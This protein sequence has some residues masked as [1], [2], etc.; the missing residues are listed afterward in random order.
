[1]INGRLHPRFVREKVS[2]KQR[3]G[4][5]VRDAHTVVFVISD[6]PVSF[7]AFARLFRDRTKCDNALFLDGGY[8]PSLY[9]PELKHGDNLLPL[10][11]MIGEFEKPR[12]ADSN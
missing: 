9:V 3:S 8:V 4:V 6:N 2:L 11:L 12:P 7:A 5:G 10:G 1:M